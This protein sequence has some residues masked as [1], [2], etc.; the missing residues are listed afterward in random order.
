[1]LP[2]SFTEEDYLLQRP[3]PRIGTQR[4]ATNIEPVDPR[5]ST[6]E[7]LV[8]QHRVA[9]RSAVRQRFPGPAISVLPAGR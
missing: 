2:G 4:H 6:M 7:L 9:G 8:G 3:A 5:F 1:V